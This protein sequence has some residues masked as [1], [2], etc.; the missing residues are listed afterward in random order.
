MKIKIIKITS[1]TDITNFVRE[2]QKVYGDITVKKGRY[3][4]DGKSLMGMFSLD[5]S[6]GLTVEYPETAYSFEE[7]I[8]PFSV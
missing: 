5:G 8:M 6:T 3:V 2:A 4:V 7:F 1:V